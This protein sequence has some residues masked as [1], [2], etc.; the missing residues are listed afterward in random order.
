MCFPYYEAIAAKADCHR[1]TVAE[2]LKALEWAGVLSWQNR[3][4]RALVRQR[5]L[6][7]L[8]GER[9]ARSAMLRGDAHGCVAS[10]AAP[11]AARAP[12]RSWW[13]RRQTALEAGNNK[14]SAMSIMGY[15][16]GPW[17]PIA[18]PR[19]AALKCGLRR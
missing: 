16:E 18:T 4:T 9:R 7:R 19:H 10:G 13:K 8:R 2:A 14:T 6:P 15:P 1:S 3:I 17:R 11:R 12:S 5:D